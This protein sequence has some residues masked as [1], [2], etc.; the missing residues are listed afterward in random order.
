MVSDRPPPSGTTKPAR[1]ER[2]I[3]ALALLTGAPGVV[4]AL[5]LLWAGGYSTRAQWTLSILIVGAW[6]AV[7]LTLRERVTRPLQTVANMLVR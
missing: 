7:V 5:L 2:R 4:A 3:L 1:F 6:L